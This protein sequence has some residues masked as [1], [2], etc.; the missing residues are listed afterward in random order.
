MYTI[1]KKTI[2]GN[3]TI[4]ENLDYD[5]ATG[6]IQNLYSRYLHA[7]NKELRQNFILGNNFAIIYDGKD[8][9]EFEIKE[10]RNVN[11]R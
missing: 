5:I 7:S 1:Q 6:I 11:S 3:I 10:Q 9:V 2:R 4:S 8:R